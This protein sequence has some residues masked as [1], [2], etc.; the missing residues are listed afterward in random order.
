MISDRLYSLCSIL[1]C[2]II[3]SFGGGCVTTGTVDGRKPD[4]VKDNTSVSHDKKGKDSTKK[5]F[6]E[7][8]FSPV[9][10]AENLPLSKAYSIYKSSKHKPTGIH[11]YG[12]I[13]FVIVN[14]DTPQKKDR[15]NAKGRAMLRSQAMLR[16]HF[17]LPRTFSFQNRQLEDTQY[18]SE[19]FYRY[20]LA[21]S[22]KDI[23]AYK[24]ERLKK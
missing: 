19:K 14:I 11:I 20:C 9:I 24:K 2:T 12:G 18:Y 17:S 21:Y 1:F 8:K 5:E 6:E 15:R 13:V 4:S 16:K 23:Q 3:L 7:G 22:L 10:K